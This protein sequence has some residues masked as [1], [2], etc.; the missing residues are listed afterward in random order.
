VELV[1]VVQELGA[2]VLVVYL[3]IPLSGLVIV[4]TQLPLVRLV[5]VVQVLVVQKAVMVEILLLQEL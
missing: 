4:T 2:V 3:L 5:L 1:V